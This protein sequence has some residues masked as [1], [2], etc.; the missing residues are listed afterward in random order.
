MATFNKKVPS[1][2]SYKP[3]SDY[4]ICNMIQ[5]KATLTMR[6]YE[7]F[8]PARLPNL[9]DII[10]A[11]KISRGKFNGYAAMKKRC[12]DQLTAFF[13]NMPHFDRIWVDFTWHEKNKR[14][15]KD[16]VA[17]GKKF[18]FDAMVDAGVIEND[19]W[20][21]IDGWSDSF[22]VSPDKTGVQLDIREVS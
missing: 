13:K 9:N 8:I 3:V 22:V 21:Q 18:I 17:V 4:A 19:G 20:K 10:A 2:D 5:G 15:D 16:N 12:T 11:A 1:L 7:I 6:K 14:R